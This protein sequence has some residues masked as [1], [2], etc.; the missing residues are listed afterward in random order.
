MQLQYKMFLRIKIYNDYNLCQVMR[1]NLLDV[2]KIIFTLLSF[3][4]ILVNCWVDFVHFRLHEQ[5]TSHFSC[6]AYNQRKI[7]VV[8][9]DLFVGSDN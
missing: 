5:N 8:L 7:T 1:P 6:C 3:L 4:Y 9:V 2:I